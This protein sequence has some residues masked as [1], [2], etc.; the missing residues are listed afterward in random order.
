MVAAGTLV[1]LSPHLDD[2]VLSIGA[3]MHAQARLGTDVRVVTVFANDP[4]SGDPPGEWD[5]LC[6]FASAAAGARAR[7]EEDVRA[8]A[9]VGAEPRWLAFADDS[10]GREPD[11]DEVW[12]SIQ[13]VVADSAV[14]LVPGFPL[15]HSDH[16]WLTRLVVERRTELSPTLGFYAEQPYARAVLDRGDPLPP[17]FARVPTNAADRLAKLRAA[18]QYRSQLR[19]L[20]TRSLIRALGE[21]W[22]RG[23]EL[24]ALPG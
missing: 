3:Y 14:L 10:Y 4:A 24:L 21:E 11:P 22:L 19:P 9:I 5:V 13:R 12:A 8:C 23:G 16:A 6:G 17:E 15:R 20:G 2:A 7:R 1:V 18:S